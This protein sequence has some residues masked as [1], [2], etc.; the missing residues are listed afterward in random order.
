MEWGAGFTQE[1]PPVYHR[2]TNTL[3][4]KSLFNPACLWTVG[5]PGAPRGRPHRQASG[6]FDPVAVRQRRWHLSPPGL[7]PM[8][9][10]PAFWFPADLDECSFSEFLCQHRCVNTPGSF[11]C[12]CPPGYYVYEDGRSCEG[13]VQDRRR[14]YGHYFTV[15]ELNKCSF[16]ISISRQFGCSVTQGKYLGSCE[17]QYD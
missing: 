9:T 2:L 4:P 12:I 8:S 1:R 17:Q 11:S 13:K 6:G 14:W 16:L 3:T 15:T 10:Y 5:G 7:F